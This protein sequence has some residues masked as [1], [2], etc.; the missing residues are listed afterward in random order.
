[1]DGAPPAVLYD[2]S[3]TVVALLFPSHPLRA[4]AACRSAW[5]NGAL[6]NR[7]RRILHWAS[8]GAIAA[9]LCLCA[10][11]AFLGSA[12]ATALFNSLPLAAGWFLL[13]A[14]LVAGLLLNLGGKG[15][16]FKRSSFLSSLSRLILIGNR[17]LRRRSL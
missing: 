8:L 6:M 9:L 4:I 10:V 1:M 5:F 14:M 16:A 17:S 13:A 2:R 15:R 7:L 12:R 11:G 3:L